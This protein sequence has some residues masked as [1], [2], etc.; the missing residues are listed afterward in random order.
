M[1]EDIKKGILHGMLF[2]PNR[3][4]QYLLQ[5]G[6]S[7]RDAVEYATC[8]TITSLGLIVGVLLWSL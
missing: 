7:Y 6:Y 1:D 2:Q 4:V 5:K 8:G 3:G